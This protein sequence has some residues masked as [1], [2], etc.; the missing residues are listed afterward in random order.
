MNPVMTPEVR[1]MIEAL[2]YRPEVS[3]ILPFHPKVNLKTEMAHYLKIA[4]DKVE[5]LLIKDYP[6]ETCA[7]IM[8]KLQ[9]IIN[10]LNFNTHKKS[11]AIYASLVFEKVFYL[12][13]DVEEKIIVDESFEIRD[14]VYNQTQSQ[15]YLLLLLSAKESHIYLGN[16]N[17]F[18]RIVSDIPESVLPFVDDAPERV[19]NFSD[20]TERKQIVTGKFLQHIDNALHGVLNTYK[21][22][23]FVFGAEKILGHFKKLTKH[24]DSIVRYMQGNYDEATFPQLKEMLQPLIAAWEELK[25]QSLLKRLDEAASQKK[26]VTGI[27]EVWHQVLNNKGRLLVVEKNYRYAAQHGGTEDT[28]DELIA[29]YNEFSYIRDAVDDV[30]EKVLK[31]GGDVQFVD[32]DLLKVYDHIALIEY[33]R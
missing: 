12:D 18:E 10:N 23:L 26:L 3:V 16:S 13:I 5:Q 2:H 15:K 32:N 4:A 8:R 25:Q 24:T 9:G 22:P 11:I 6:E 20:M 17:T 1:E 31:N 28:I 33:Y 19:A 30:I 27:K 21:L 14:L 7:L 29:P